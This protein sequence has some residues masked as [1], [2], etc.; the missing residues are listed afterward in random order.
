MPVTSLTIRLLMAFNSDH[1]N[2]YGSAL[3]MS[4]LVTA[5]RIQMYPYTLESPWTPTAITRRMISMSAAVSET[6]KISM[7]TSIGVKSSICLRDLFFL[8][9]AF[10]SSLADW[11]NL[12]VDSSLSDH[13]DENVVRL[14][15]NLD[16][17]R[18]HLAENSDPNTRSREGMSHDEILVNA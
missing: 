12:V 7:H 1:W 5:R 18:R 6:W 2:S 15:H 8:A 16:S 9:K 11:T 4:R 10:F 13:G 3:I 17:F 14:A